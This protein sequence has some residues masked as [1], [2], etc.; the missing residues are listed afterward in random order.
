MTNIQREVLFYVF[1]GFFSLI[2]IFS[3][4]ALLGFV[5]RSDPAFRKWAIGGFLGAVT[6]AVVG[7]F[8][9]S[10]LA[11]PALITVTLVPPPDA[12]TPLVLDHGTYQYDEVAESGKVT[13]QKGDLVAA[14]GDDNSWQ[15]RLPG[16]VSDKAVRLNFQDAAGNPWVAGP[17]YPNYIQQK[18]RAGQKATPTASTSPARRVPIAMAV[19]FAAEP[20]STA[21]LQKQADVKFNNYARSIGNQG[22]RPYWEWR[23][24]V[25]EKPEV[26][27]TIAQVDYLLH[28]TFPDPFRTSRDRDKQFELVASGWGTFRIVITIHYTN[29]TEA[30]TSY[31]LNFDNSWPAPSAAHAKLDKIRAIQTGGTAATGWTFDISVDGKKTLSVPKRDYTSATGRNEFLPE[32]AGRWDMGEVKIGG[33]GARIEITGRR[34]TGTETVTGTG[35]LKANGQVEVA[36]TNKQDP[37][38]GSFVFTFSAS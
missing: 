19:V 10:F 7:L 28:P 24:F 20:G 34:V 6:T 26:L 9:L 38:K 17:F 22:G 33:D 12:A 18:M 15:V 37:R 13:T 21:A 14:A 2:G 36:V 30:K 35:T 8:R 23:V 32:A 5:K 11:T 3:L 27:N 29:G 1:T 16:E 4:L 25:D 31:N